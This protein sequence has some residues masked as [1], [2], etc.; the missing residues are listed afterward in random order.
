MY[1]LNFFNIKQVR[2]QRISDHQPVIANGVLSWNIMMHCKFTAQGRYNNAFELTETQ[3]QYQHRLE[4]IALIL[5]QLC[6]ADPQIHII[7]LQE[8]PIQPDDIEIFIQCCLVYPSLQKFAATLQDKQSYT[9]WGLLT[10][11]NSEIY[12]YQ[13]TDLG[14]NQSD[15]PI[16]GLFLKDRVQGFTLTHDNKRRYII[17]LHFPFDLTKKYPGK[18]ARVVNMIASEQQKNNHQNCVIAGDFNFLV[19]QFPAIQ[20]LGHVFMPQN[21][22]T[23]YHPGHDS[24]NSLETVDAIICVQPAANEHNGAEILLRKKFN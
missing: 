5:A 7:C 3:T 22:S 10:L 2:K 15:L 21:N 18:M 24:H 4:R 17:N 12:Q 13:T 16:D 20:E 11:I 6:K 19:T 14:W 23:E 9:D 1:P 8:A